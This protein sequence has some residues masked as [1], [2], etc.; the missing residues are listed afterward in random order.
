VV[1]TAMIEHVLY[2]EEVGAE[3]CRILK[4]GGLLYSELPFIQPVHEGAYDFT[5]YTLFGH[6]HLF[7]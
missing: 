5:K 2:P 6:R 7:N 4:V 1:T 3:I